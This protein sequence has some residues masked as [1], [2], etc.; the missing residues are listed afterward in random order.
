MEEKTMH[1]LYGDDSD[2]VGCGKCYFCID[3][4]DCKK[5]GCGSEKETN[6]DLYGDL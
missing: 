5:F 6:E 3:C 1:E 2:H 4:G